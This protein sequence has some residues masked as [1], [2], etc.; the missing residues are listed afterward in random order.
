MNCPV[1]RLSAKGDLLSFFGEDEESPLLL[2]DLVDDTGN[3]SP[4]EHDPDV[5]ADMRRSPHG[6][7]GSPA[8]LVMS[9]RQF[10]ERWSPGTL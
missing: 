8:A 10:P 3:R 9:S 5:L 6:H 1:A 4:Q 2:I 7:P